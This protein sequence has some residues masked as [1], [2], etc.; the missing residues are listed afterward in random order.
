MES[1]KKLQEIQTASDENKIFLMKED[2]IEYWNLNQD[3]YTSRLPFLARNLLSASPSSVPSERLFS[4]ASL[5]SAGIATIT[6]F[7]YLQ[8]F[9]LS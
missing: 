6:T 2:P 4:I 9:F 8:Y 3:K 1:A 5:L 7:Y